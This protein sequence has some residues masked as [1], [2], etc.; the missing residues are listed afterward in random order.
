[1]PSGSLPELSQKRY[2]TPVSF[3]P[4]NCK[5]P[6]RS[7]ATIMILKTFFLA[8]TI[9]AFGLQSAVAASALGLSTD[10][11][12]NPS[13]EMVAQVEAMEAAMAAM[14]KGEKPAV[15]LQDAID[16]IREL[17]DKGEDKDALF[18]M[19]RAKLQCPSVALK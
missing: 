17:A 14:A 10:E 12:T 5:A 1:M 9:S 2:V 19:R 6:R 13:P 18:A 15:E 11:W 3:H 4:P 16:K 7:A 8:V